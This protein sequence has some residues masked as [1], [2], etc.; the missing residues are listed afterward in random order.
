MHLVFLSLHIYKVLTLKSN[1]QKLIDS[2]NKTSSTIRAI[3]DFLAHSVYQQ[4]DTT[5]PLFLKRE[6]I[7]NIFPF[8]RKGLCVWM[9][10]QIKIR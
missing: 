9:C 8:T 4:V 2:G 6:K 7:A 5:Q 1:H 10:F 3:S